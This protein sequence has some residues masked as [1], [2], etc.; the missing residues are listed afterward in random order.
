MIKLLSISRKRRARNRY[1]VVRRERER[2][3][4]HT[5]TSPPNIKFAEKQKERQQERERE[6]DTMK[7]EKG[8]TQRNILYSTY[9]LFLID[10]RQ[11]ISDKLVLF[12][13]IEDSDAQ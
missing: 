2:N 4:I 7:E 3:N 10:N 9:I 1:S 12:F 13:L 5:Q 8:N 11:H 6:R